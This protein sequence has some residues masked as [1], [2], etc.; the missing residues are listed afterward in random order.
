MGGPKLAESVMKSA[1]TPLEFHLQAVPK[2]SINDHYCQLEEASLCDINLQRSGNNPSKI[3][4]VIGDTCEKIPLPMGC[5]P[6]AT[7]T[8]AYLGIL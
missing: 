7:R 2:N 5:R 1:P 8:V 4:T 6:F 3:P